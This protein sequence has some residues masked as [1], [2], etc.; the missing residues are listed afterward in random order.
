MFRSIWM[1]GT[2]AVM[3]LASDTGVDLADV[4]SVILLNTINEIT[5]TG[6]TRS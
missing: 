3:Y 2:R 4:G 6:G 1:S 5:W